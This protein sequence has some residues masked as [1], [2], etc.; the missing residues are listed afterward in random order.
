M[1]TIPQLDGFSNWHEITHI[2]TSTRTHTTS[3]QPEHLK[4]DRLSEAVDIK[5]SI[6]NFNFI[7][8]SLETATSQLHNTPKG[9]Q[10][11]K[12]HSCA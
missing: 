2:H 11:C 10:V 1:S 3:K 12:W 8:K 5:G 6:Y 9:K 7:S 4:Q